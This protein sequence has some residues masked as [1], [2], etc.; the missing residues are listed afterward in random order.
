MRGGQRLQTPFTGVPRAHMQ[1]IMWSCRGMHLEKH[2]EQ[3]TWT[4]NS[5]SMA[6]SPRGL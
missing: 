4:R 3:H 5:S 2:A 1:R 6:H